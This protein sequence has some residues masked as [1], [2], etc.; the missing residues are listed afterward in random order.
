MSGGTQRALRPGRKKTALTPDPL[1]AAFSPLVVHV[2][3]GKPET[4]LWC[5]SCLLPS[6]VRFSLLILGENGAYGEAGRMTLCTECDPPGGEGTG[7]LLPS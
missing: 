4:G 3:A 5:D 2:A 7:E 6:A 1:P